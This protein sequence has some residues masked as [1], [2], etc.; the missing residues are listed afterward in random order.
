MIQATDDTTDGLSYKFEFFLSCDVSLSPEDT[1][2]AVNYTNNQTQIL[3]AGID[4]TTDQF[5]GLYHCLPLACGGMKD[6]INWSLLSSSLLHHSLGW[7]L[8]SFHIFS[9]VFCALDLTSLSC[10]SQSVTLL[11]PCTCPVHHSL[12]LYLFPAPVVSIAVC[13]F[14]CSLH[15]S[16]PP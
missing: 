4:S 14:T 6:S 7:S 15:L 10:P 8:H 11:V 3:K 5:I 9:V 12:W 1:L 2:V 13:D 16:C